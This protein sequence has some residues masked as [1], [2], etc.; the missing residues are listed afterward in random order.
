VHGEVE[1]DGVRMA[2]GWSFV[3]NVA[4]GKVS[5]CERSV[6]IVD[7][8]VFALLRRGLRHVYTKRSRGSEVTRGRS[9]KDV[10]LR[11]TL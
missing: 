7:D 9:G 11:L 3:C 4:R 2:A 8:D 1:S 5:C 10:W 6:V